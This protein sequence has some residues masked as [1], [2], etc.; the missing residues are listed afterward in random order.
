MW[1]LP[2]AGGKPG[3]WRGRWFL[4]L[5]RIQRVGAGRQIHVGSRK[6]RLE[7]DGIDRLLPSEGFVPR[8]GGPPAPGRPGCE[9]TAAA[10]H[11]RAE[12]PGEAPPGRLAGNQTAAAGAAL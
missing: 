10:D 6:R 3:D 2:T 7:H 11:G 12:G 9:F 8:A 4:L 5:R 1:P